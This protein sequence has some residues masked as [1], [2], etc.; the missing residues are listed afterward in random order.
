MHKHQTDN[1]SYILLKYRK[2]YELLIWILKWVN[3]LTLLNPEI[4]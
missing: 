2:L 1:P 4:K 3:F